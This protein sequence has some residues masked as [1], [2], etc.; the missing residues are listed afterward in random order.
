[1]LWIIGGLVLAIFVLRYFSPKV[2]RVDAS[3]DDQ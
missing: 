1:M 2:Y 3:G